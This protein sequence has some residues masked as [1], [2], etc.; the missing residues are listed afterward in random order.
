MLNQ[1]NFNTLA[2]ARSHAIDVAVAI[3]SSSNLG[4]EAPSIG[5]ILAGTG[6]FA[7]KANGSNDTA[8]NELPRANPQTP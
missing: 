3:I 4:N 7:A 8:S 2:T 5:V 6:L 1:V